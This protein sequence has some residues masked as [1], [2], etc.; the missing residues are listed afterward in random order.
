MIIGSRGSRLALWQAN[1][2]KE[3]VEQTYPNL[4]LSIDIIKTTGDKMADVPLGRIGVKG[5]FTKEI[6]EALLEKKIDLAVHSLK[7]M[8]TEWPAGL[9]IAAITE[10][11][12]P[13]DA[14][15]AKNI[16]R[17]SELPQGAIVGTSSLR[18]QCQ[19]R[20][21]RPDLRVVDL[22]GNVDTRLKKLESNDLQAIVLASA[23]L[24]RL[25]CRD[26]ITEVLSTDLIM[27][28]I[29]QGALAIQTREDDLRVKELIS[30]LS[31]PPTEAAAKAERAFLKRLG[32][33]CQAPIAAYAKIE[34]RR[35]SLAGLI[36]TPDGRL[37]LRD[38][39]SGDISR[40]EPLG[41]RLAERLLNRGGK[42]ILNEVYG[43]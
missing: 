35:L 4:K 14:L 30:F 26:R 8:P 10:R 19:I 16:K 7:D 24:I 22:R 28:A 34:D 17:F 9:T 31:H 40:G 1:W 5:L 29:G 33:G 25:G 36:A 12:D 42:E 27:P 21:W 38:E 6:E 41:Y 3:R 18:R 20:H 15:I 13:R 23:G 43:R 32:G 2:V 39:I 11:E 37:F